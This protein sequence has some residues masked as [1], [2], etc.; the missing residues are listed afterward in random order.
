MCGVLNLVFYLLFNLLSSSKNIQIINNKS[1]KGNWTKT[2]QLA[3]CHQAIYLPVNIKFM[4]YIIRFDVTR[5]RVS[6]FKLGPLSYLYS[7]QRQLF[8]RELH[9]WIWL[10]EGA[11]LPHSSVRSDSFC[12]LG[13]TMLPFNSEKLHW[14]LP[15]RSGN[16]PLLT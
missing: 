8:Q 6:D 9:R 1:G 11:R 10:S 13:K 14:K 7:G 2:Q 3:Y 15:Q 5:L 12:T 16:P 4:L